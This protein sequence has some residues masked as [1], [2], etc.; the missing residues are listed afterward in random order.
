M[1]FSGA[2]SLEDA[3]N[4]L[5][6]QRLCK[7]CMDRELEITFIPCGHLVTCE[8]CAQPL[9]KCPICRKLIKSHVKTRM[10]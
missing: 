6:D 5:K 10:S 9:K 8:Q 3:Y 7:I 4:Q 1:I 2:S